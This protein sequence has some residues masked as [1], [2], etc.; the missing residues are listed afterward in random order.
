M[1]PF[2]VVS[3][4]SALVPSGVHI[5][6]AGIA[7]IGSDGDEARSVGKLQHPLERHLIEPVVPAKRLARR[8]VGQPRIAGRGKKRGQLGRLHSKRVIGIEMRRLKRLHIGFVAKA[9]GA[10]L[11]F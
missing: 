3:P 10:E 6:I 9:I 4:A 2:C 1:V 5:L 8:P 7:V 11:E